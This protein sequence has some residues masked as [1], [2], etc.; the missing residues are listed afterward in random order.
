[1][2]SQNANLPGIAIKPELAEAQRVADLAAAVSGATEDRVDATTPTTIPSVQRA[3]DRALKIRYFGS[4]ELNPDRYGTDFKKIADE[5]LAHLAA[6]PGARLKV[7]V[8]IEAPTPSGFDASKVR[9]ILENANALK[10]EQ[11]EFE[12]R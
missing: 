11:S 10:F 7:R 12:E 2:T 4:K 1:M 3:A 5:V 9:T 8:D 6:T